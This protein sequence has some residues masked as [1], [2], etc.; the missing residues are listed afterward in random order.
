M[1]LYLVDANVLIRAHEDYYP[2]DRIPQFWDWL[3]VMGT[4][5]VIQIPREIY[6]EV[7]P[8]Q[9]PLADWIRR[10]EN[11]AALILREPVD[12]DLVQRVLNDG[13]A[14]DLND[15][16]VEEIGLDPFLIAAALAGLDRVV[17]TREV[18]KPTATRAKRRIPDVCATFGITSI[19]D[20]RLYSILKFSI[21]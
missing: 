10:P 18:S 1:T 5:E 12:K 15:V 19:T 8:S 14:R 2:V 7:R 6:D 21:P 4:S 16:E 9:G 17:V 13:Y 11:Q 20:Y 3:V